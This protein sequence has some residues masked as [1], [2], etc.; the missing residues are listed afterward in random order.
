MF[1]NLNPVPFQAQS[2]R[3]GTRQLSVLLLL[4]VSAKQ[5]SLPGQ[6]VSTSQHHYKYPAQCMCPGSEHPLINK[7]IPTSVFL[8]ILKA[9]LQVCL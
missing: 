9:F 1:T 6:L 4:T 7:A 5:A 2:L 8:T 3:P